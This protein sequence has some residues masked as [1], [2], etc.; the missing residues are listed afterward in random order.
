MS[1]HPKPQKAHLVLE[2]GSV[3]AG[4][5][6]GGDVS[7]VGEV[8]FSTSLTGY[9]EMLTDPSYAGQ[10]LMPTYP[11]IG[12]YGINAE[13]FESR[14]IQVAGFVVR[15]WCDLPSHMLSEFN[16]HEFL[17][18]QGVPGI[19]GVDTRAITRRLRTRGVM[20][21][22]IAVG[23]A[24]EE[25]VAKLRKTP[26]YDSTDFVRKVTTRTMYRWPRPA[27]APESR[28]RVVVTDCGVKHNIL[29]LL[30]ARGCEVIAV[31]ASVNAED[32]L[33]F[34]PSG[35]L[36]S[37]GPGDP[38]R[39]GYAADTARGLIGKVPILGICLGQQ[40]IAHALGGKTYKLKFGHR[41]GNHPVKDLRTGRV[42]ITAQ[43]HGYAVDGDSLPPELEVSHINLNDQTVE[44]LRHRSA[45]L[46]TIQYHSEASP[47]PLDNEY[48]FDEFMGMMRDAH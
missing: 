34:N 13:D 14:R 18:S 28:Y 8:V 48:I 15:E 11:L 1:T 42:H 21:G 43:N 9:Q 33:S 36:F 40:V 46:L 29:R 17:A 22:I 30:T 41:G 35:V 4:E 37:P 10:I 24:P 44:G 5:S 25:A 19:S 47:G 12:N 7:T 39:L 26:T 27:D 2:D 20:M 23:L 45:S 16:V 6:F 31:P 32:I 38:A 3:Y